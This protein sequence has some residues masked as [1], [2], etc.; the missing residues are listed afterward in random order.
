MWDT[1]HPK[2]KK[3]DDVIGE[4]IALQNLPFHF[5]EGLGFRRVIQ[6]ALP[7]Y[8]LRGRQFFTD[9][10]CDEIHTKIATK[11]GEKLNFFFKLS[12]ATDIWSEPSANVS[13]LSLTAHG[14]TEDFTRMQIVL[15]CCS[16][17]GRHTGD[18]ICDN[19]KMMLR[20]WNIQ[21]EQLYCLI[22]DGGSNMVRAM[23]LANIPDVSCTV[24]KLQLCV[25][26]ALETCEVKELLAKCKKISGHFN[27]SQIAQDQLTKIQTE[28][29]NQ[30][31]LRVIQDCV[32][33]YIIVFN[34][35]HLP[36]ILIS[37]Q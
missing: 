29:L 33:R 16:L 9:H 34:F 36:I 24:H 2:A 19:F 35:I 26:S 22:R 28:Q 8:Q 13:L 6:T 32:T 15:K 17:H 3:M 11:I 12:F 23:Y 1:S 14:I 25:R 5:V 7:N 37:I 4:M 31:A 27:H 30:P 21:N 10:I 18:I 20:D